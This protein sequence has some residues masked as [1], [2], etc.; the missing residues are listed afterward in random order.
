VE[1]AQWHE[2]QD[3]QKNG[4]AFVLAGLALESAVDN[5][6]VCGVTS[7][8]GCGLQDVLWEGVFRARRQ[9]QKSM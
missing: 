2:L 9:I 7:K 3:G 1:N 6:E 5:G 8:K 4:S